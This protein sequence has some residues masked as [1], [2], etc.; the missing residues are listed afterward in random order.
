MEAA[1][2][3][4][5]SNGPLTNLVSDAYDVEVVVPVL[6]PAQLTVLV[7]SG[8]FM[9]LKGPVGKSLVVDGDYPYELSV[10]PMGVAG[11][12]GSPFTGIGV[13][14]L[15]TGLA[16]V[17]VEN[18]FTNQFIYG[19]VTVQ[20]VPPPAASGGFWESSY[21]V[22]T[23]SEPGRIAIGSNWA[24]N[25]WK[26][27]AQTTSIL[28]RLE[29]SENANIRWEHLAGRPVS[30]C[31]AQSTPLARLRRARILFARLTSQ[32]CYCPTQI[33]NRARQWFSR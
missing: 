10:L 25:G 19:Q 18:T 13:I 12:V 4:I 16:E 28:V 23:C 21:P 7:G 15:Q 1:T 17:K 9:A 2:G 31:Q 26:G 32:A 14:G 3:P 29:T 30:V 27:A 5:K 6:D 22:E 24:S 33:G 20:E 11:V 8:A